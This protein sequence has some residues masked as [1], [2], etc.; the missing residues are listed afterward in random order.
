MKTLR[1][2]EK[3]LLY[4]LKSYIDNNNSSN[5]RFTDITKN[6]PDYKEIEM[7][8]AVSKLKDD[9]FLEIMYYNSK[10]G[11]I[12]VKVSKLREISEL[13]F[14]SKGYDIYSSVMDMIK[15]HKKR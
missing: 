13:S 5:A 7:I 4:L 8:D 6:F 12:F 14:T 2:T 10:P 15:P 1:L 11:S 3:I 9:G